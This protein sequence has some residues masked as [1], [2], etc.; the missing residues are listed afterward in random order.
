MFIPKESYV[1]RKVKLNH[2]INTTIGTFTKGSVMTVTGYSQISKMFDLR[3]N[4]SGEILYCCSMSNGN[5]TDKFN[6]ID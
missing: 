1:G 2:D 3:D 5:N 4:D 6:F